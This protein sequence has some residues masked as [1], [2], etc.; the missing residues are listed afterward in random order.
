MLPVHYRRERCHC[1][2]QAGILGPTAR[3][4]PWLPKEEDGARVKGGQVYLENAFHR[5]NTDASRSQV[6]M[7]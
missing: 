5:Q 4:A 1:P 2:G 7:D 6:F 3:E